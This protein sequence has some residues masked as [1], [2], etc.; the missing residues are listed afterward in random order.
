MFSETARNLYRRFLLHFAEDTK[1][2]V[3]ELQYIDIDNDDELNVLELIAKV[4]LLS[5]IFS[6]SELCRLC[7]FKVHFYMNSG[8]TYVPK[9]IY[10][11]YRTNL[12]YSEATSKIAELSNRFI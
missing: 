8:W 4:M 9:S 12:L 10:S 5:F 7:F 3:C 1:V 2:H 11:I 6:R